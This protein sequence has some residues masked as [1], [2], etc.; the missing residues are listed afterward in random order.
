[1]QPAAVGLTQ[2]TETGRGVPTGWPDVGTAV[3]E[4]STAAQS[5]DDQRVS[6][7]TMGRLQLQ[8][9]GALGM[10]LSEPSIQLLLAVIV[11]NHG[12]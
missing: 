8:G 10:P 6:S 1:M 5:P 9:M 3:D 7:G 2:E 4:D 12:R 11:K